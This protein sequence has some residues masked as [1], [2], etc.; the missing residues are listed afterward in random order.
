MMRLFVEDFWI[1]DL[2]EEGLLDSLA[3]VELL[4]AI[5][6]EFGVRLSTDIGVNMIKKI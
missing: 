6:D 4:I 1:R 2:V 5:E 3:V